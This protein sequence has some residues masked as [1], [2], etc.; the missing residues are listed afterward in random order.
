VGQRIPQFFL[1]ALLL[2]TNS[3]SA[4]EP[5]L[6][7]PGVKEDIEFASPGGISL[8]LDAF[9][10]D[11]PGPFPACILVH[12]GGWKNGNKRVYIT[13]LFEPLAKSG[14]AWFAINYRLAPEHRWP[15]CA[16]DVKAGI[17]W[18]KAHAAEYKIDPN[19]IALI[20][21]SAGAQLAAFVAAQNDADTRVAAVVPFYCPADFEL[22][23]RTAPAQ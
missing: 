4:D 20:G 12:G 6:T 16:D 8:K 7:L 18:V 23:A 5:K 14:F 17:K 13:P 15:A 19:R 3:F 11:G 21:E 22:I 9:I 2:A 10:P 1:L